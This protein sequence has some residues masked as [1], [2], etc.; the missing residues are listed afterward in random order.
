MSTVLLPL[1][2]R[3]VL[4]AVADLASG[5]VDLL[6]AWARHGT[7]SPRLVDEFALDGEGVEG[8]SS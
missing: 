4:P 7:E 3:I 8:C 2:E 1:R 5:A 6:E